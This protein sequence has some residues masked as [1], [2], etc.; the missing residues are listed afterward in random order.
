MREDRTTFVNDFQPP[1]VLPSFGLLKLRNS[2][3][4]P[5]H[6]GF[7]CNHVARAYFH[8]DFDGS[9]QAVIPVRHLRLDLVVCAVLQLLHCNLDYGGIVF[10]RDYFETSSVVLGL[11]AM[12]SGSVGLFAGLKP[13]SYRLDYAPPTGFPAWSV[14]RNSMGALK[15]WITGSGQ[16][17]CSLLVVPFFS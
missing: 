5:V 15:T 16:S 13:L 1:V 4:L 14:L 2:N 9:F 7:D 8:L 17:L 11:Q 10:Q 12:I 3:R 6:R